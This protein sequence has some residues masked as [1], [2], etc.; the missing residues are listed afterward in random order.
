MMLVARRL[1]ELAR[2]Q[3]TPLYLCVMDLTTEPFC[4]MS[5]LVMACHRECST[6]S[7]N[8]TTPCKHLC[9]WMMDKFDVGQGLRR[10]FVL[11]PLRCSTCFLRLVNMFFTAVLRVVEKCFL[12][13]AATRDNMMQLQRKKEKVEK[14]ATSRTGRIGGRG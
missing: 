9:G 5:L 12:A 14:K 8:S 10:G 1:Q 11:T 7:A 2:K 3:D 13:D 6:T 4:G